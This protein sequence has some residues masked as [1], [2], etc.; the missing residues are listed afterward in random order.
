M[1]DDEDEYHP[2]KDELQDEFSDDEE[3]AGMKRKECQ[4]HF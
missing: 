1:D 3:Y 4:G 2:S